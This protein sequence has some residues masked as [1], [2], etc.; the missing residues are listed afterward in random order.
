MKDKD[1]DYLISAGIL[2]IVG[3][4][5]AGI[6]C[7]GTAWYLCNKVEEKSTVKTILKIVSMVGT[8]FL[9]FYHLTK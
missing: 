9:I 3:W 8:M 7:W 2:L 4:F 6:I 1:K 5:V